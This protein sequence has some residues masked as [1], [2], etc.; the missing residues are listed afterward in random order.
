MII[1]GIASIPE[2]E[3][4]LKKTVQS[5]YK[6]VDKIFIW[7]N[8]Y[9][10]PPLIEDPD[11]KIY[12]NTGSNLG[13]SGKFF[14]AHLNIGASFYYL[15]CD[16]DLIYDGESYVHLMIEG[17]KK[18]GCPVSLHGKIYGEFTLNWRKPVLN[19][20]CLDVV[21]K[22]VEVDVVGTGVLAFSS[23]F[24]GVYTTMFHRPNMADLWFSYAAKKIGLPLMV[25]AHPEGIVTYMPQKDTLWK[26]REDEEFK[27]ELVNKILALK[28]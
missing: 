4:S 27:T 7:L 21:T 1:A 26:R 23:E 3:E 15:A 22:D 5:L 24:M 14:G 25:L 2:R 11:K 8:E 12:F 17:V 13:D 10:H 28:R 6:H 19:Y 20:R 16:D 18:Y 9:D